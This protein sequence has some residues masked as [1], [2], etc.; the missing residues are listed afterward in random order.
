MKAREIGLIIIGIALLIG[1]VVYSFNT[2]LSEI[3]N[4][5]C[6]HGPTC[7]MWGTI[8]FQTQVGAGIMALV[9][10]VGL[11]FIFFVKD[12]KEYTPQN[13]IAQIMP[14]KITKEQY[15]TVLSKMQADEK[16]VFELVL[17]K[18]GSIYQSELVEKTLF[19]K[20]KMTRVL[21]KLES[22]GLVE[23][24]RRGM[25]NIVTVKQQ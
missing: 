6:S 5:S 24:K 8:N 15:S 9:I 11:Y 25:T 14:K 1:F 23:R 3:V 19:G 13:P 12:K 22:Q 18:N 16:K 10:L 21:D 2:A 4:T 20:V 7:P 17:E